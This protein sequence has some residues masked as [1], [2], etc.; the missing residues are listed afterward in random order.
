VGC[1]LNRNEPIRF[2]LSF[3]TWGRIGTRYRYAQ[4]RDMRGG[5]SILKEPRERERSLLL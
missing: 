4:Q 2:N 3:Q 5:S 1:T